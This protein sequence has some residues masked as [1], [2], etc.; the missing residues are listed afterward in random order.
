MPYCQALKDVSD[1]FRQLWA[2]SLGKRTNIKNEVVNIGPTPVKALGAT[3]QHSQVQLYIEGSYDK[4]I[5]F[6]SVEKYRS[7]VVI[8]STKEKHYL[9]KHTLNELIKCEEEAT[10]VAL[11]KQMRPNCTITIPEVNEHT[12]GQ[13]F[14]MLELATAYIGELFEINA[15]DQP[16]VELG[17]VLTY[18]LMGRSGFEKEKKEIEEFLAKKKES[19]YAV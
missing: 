1:W 11:T 13:I 2:E 15:F 12:I 18:G 17:K 16:G 8:P 19:T 4:V 9:E 10:R 5:T 3:D 6:L 14:Y 7:N